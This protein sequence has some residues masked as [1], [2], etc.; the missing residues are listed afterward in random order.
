MT[1]YEPQQSAEEKDHHA[2]EAILE[3]DGDELLRRI[4]RYS[5][6]MCGYGPVISLIAAA[7]KL[8]ANRGELVKYQTSGDASGESSRVVGYAGIVIIVKEVS[9]QVKLAREAVE[10]YVSCGN[11]IKPD[12]LI[13][14]MAQKAGV[15]ICIKKAG[16]LRGC[17]GTFEPC[18]DNT[19]EEIITNAISSATQDRRFS[20]VSSDEL[21]EL[22]YSVDILTQPKAIDSEEELDAKRYG[23]IAEA[24]SRRGLLLPDLEG[25]D[26][27]QQQIDICRQKAG[28]LP[29]EPLKLYRV[30]VKRY[31]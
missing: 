24:G 3:L 5:I 15:F 6:S 21:K 14:E 12:K 8:G 23:V 2:I 30:E 11:V 17:I 20:P 16:M 19:A 27:P 18:R 28:I 25:V 1:H 22:T 7:K 31:Q 29:N 9:P 4:H 26:T 13:P 10:T